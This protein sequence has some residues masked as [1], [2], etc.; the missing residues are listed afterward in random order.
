MIRGV[1]YGTTYHAFGTASITGHES[2]H[3]GSLAQQLDTTLDNLASLIGAAER[4]VGR[5]FPAGPATAA[6]KAYVRN[7]ADYPQVR[8]SLED[9]FGPELGVVYLQADICRTELLC[10][11]DGT[12]FLGAP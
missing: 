9:R 4:A 8:A 2:R 10:E 3:P 12:V 6:L 5:P 11:V 1:R 7:P